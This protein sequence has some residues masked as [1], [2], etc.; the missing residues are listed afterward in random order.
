M[1]TTT[2]D[3]HLAEVLARIRLS[4]TGLESWVDPLLSL[5]ATTPEEEEQKEGLLS[6]LGGWLHE[7]K[8]RVDI[9]LNYYAGG[10]LRDAVMAGEEPV[11]SGEL[12]K[13]AYL[14]PPDAS[15][16]PTEQHARAVGRGLLERCIGAGE[17]SL[18]IV[19]WADSVRH[20]QM[21]AH[22][23]LVEYRADGA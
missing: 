13:N 8:R 7:P 9:A 12:A 21:D 6:T 4:G 14:A 23:G 1:P 17:Y 3:Q 5:E 22:P 20:E 10:P 11:P 2:F 16:T 15:M 18:P 19:L